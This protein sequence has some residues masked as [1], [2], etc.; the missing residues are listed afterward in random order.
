MTRKQPRFFR[1]GST[2]L[3]RAFLGVSLAFLLGLTPALIPAF[4]I[5]EL[6]AVAHTPKVNPSFL[7]V[8]DVSRLV[9]QGRELYQT[10]RF[11]EAVTTWQQAVAAFEAQGDTLNQ[12]IVLN[13]LSLAEQQLGQW[14]QAANAIAKS[15]KLLQTAQDNPERVS[16]LAKALNVQGSLQFAQGQVEEALKTWQEA[17][18]NYAQVEDEAGQIGSSINQAQAQQALGLYLQARKTLDSVEQSLQ[19]QPNLQLKTTGFRSL[20]NV[21]RLVG[22]LNESQKV[23]EKSLDTAKQLKSLPA[24]S[25]A[26]LSLGNTARAQQQYEDALYY[27]QQVVISF[28]TLTTKIKAQLNQLSLLIELGKSQQALALWS[29]IQ[30]QLSSFPPSR[31]AVYNRINLVESLILLRQNSTTET[32]SWSQ[33]AQEAAVAVQQAK[34]L[35]DK[36]AEAYALGYF[37][38]LYEQ[39]QDWSN[40]QKLTQQALLL[41]QEINASDI[42][43]QWQWQLGR[44]LKAQGDVSQATAAY[45][46]AFNTL[47]SVRRDLVAIN[48]DVQFSF[49]ESVEPV[50]RGLVDLLLR[51]AEPNDANLELARDVIESLQLAE[52]DDFFRSA[53]L[54]GQIVPLEKVEQTETA[55][56]YPIILADRLETILSLPGQP[57]RH[58]AT[59]VPQSQV[60]DTLEQLRLNL[61]KPYTSPDGKSLSQKVYDWLIRPAEADL[62]QSQIK[63]LVFVLDGALRNVPMAALYDGEQY[64]VEQYSVALTPGLQLLNPQPLGRRSIE[65]LVGGLTEE[66]HGFSAL[67][68]VS[69]ELAQ[70][71]SE[72]P[73][74]VLLNQ[75]FTSKALQDQI[76]E[77]PFPV[78]HLA[79]HGQFSSNAEETFILA[80]DKRIKVNELKQLLRTGDLTESEAIEL[81]VLSACETAAGDKRAA[82]GLAGVA[83][84]A[85]ARS[86]LA[87]LWSLDD[88]S[89]ARFVSQFYHELAHR[90]VTKAE[91]LQKAQLSLL[92][93]QDYRAPIHWAPYVLVGNWL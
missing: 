66:R 13:Y 17:A 53:C 48:P 10:G 70:I 41:A 55:V 86:T 92:Q 39:T 28:N 54:E 25:A 34:S 88:K 9:Q 16:I 68:N 6:S 38:G 12:A 37:G 91:A 59:P 11:S 5:G 2:F 36:R 56:I 44:L 85:G 81:L 46:A 23:L 43:Y 58:F 57:L 74:Q 79:T 83:V 14:F 1:Q 80:W 52:L 87:S 93:N 49:R 7:A 21:L 26:L 69:R 42:A 84:Q 73:S 78:V 61:E 19:Q 45:E 18:D 31:T 64:L 29:Q 4:R 60:E 50:Y 40:A 65:A 77:L 35:D 22:D 47:Q 15:L 71:E 24:I 62:T 30:S 3:M 27:Y 32:P 82:L 33:I 67:P 75:T 20:G 76:G 90:K 8:T 51:P 72:L 63:T 89:G